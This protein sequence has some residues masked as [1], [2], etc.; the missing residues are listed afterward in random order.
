VSAITRD[1][2]KAKVANLFTNRELG[3]YVVFSK[4]ALAQMNAIAERLKEESRFDE[5]QLIQE[6]LDTADHILSYFTPKAF[7][8][9]IENGVLLPCTDDEFLQAIDAIKAEGALMEFFVVLPVLL[10]AEVA[11][12]TKSFY[13]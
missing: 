7:T 2:L 6:D 11:N 12:E 1:T 3:E 10:V 5:S 13:R 4:E 8:G 9:R